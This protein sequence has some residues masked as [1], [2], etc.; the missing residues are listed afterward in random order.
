MTQFQ[1]LKSQTE[2]ERQ[3]RQDRRRQFVGDA[4]GAL[5]LLVT[6][7]GFLLIIHGAGW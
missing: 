7:G 5:A 1:K 3:E 6:F 4:V 2:I